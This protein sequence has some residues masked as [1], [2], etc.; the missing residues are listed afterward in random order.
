MAD[1]EESVD[2]S[3]SM[4]SQLDAELETDSETSHETQPKTQ[5]KKPKRKRKKVNTNTEWKWTPEKEAQLISAVEA[6]DFLWDVGH[7]DHKSRILRDAAWQEISENIFN[8]ECDGAQLSAKWSNLRIQFK[9]YHSKSKQS[10]SGQGIDEHKVS[11]KHF[12]RMLFIAAAEDE[13]STISESNLV[14][15]FLFLYFY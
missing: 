14:S 15:N 4:L 6:K 2:Y 9:S 8:A 3:E 13:Q 10:K 11:W 1:D 5:P 7:K 12:S